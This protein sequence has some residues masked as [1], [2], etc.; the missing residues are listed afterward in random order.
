MLTGKPLFPGRDYAHQLDLILDVL[1][2]LLR[3]LLRM[4]SVLIGNVGTP[5]FD[6]FI[7][8]TSRRSREY[9]RS[10]PIRKGKSFAELVPTA[11][12]NAL[13]FLARTVVSS[14][15]VLNSNLVLTAIRAD[16]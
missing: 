8:I 15:S 14:P 9:I 7:A 6:E 3:S 4:K 13:D 12:A 1:G 2:E 11:S 16:L 10:L 5:S